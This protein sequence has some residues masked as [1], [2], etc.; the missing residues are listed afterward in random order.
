M[1]RWNQGRTV[2]DELIQRRD[3]ERV[4]AS[5]EHAEAELAQARQHL[6]SAGLVLDLDPVGA[7][8]LAYDAAR[9]ALAAILMNQGL[10]ATSRGGHVAVYETVRAQLDPP[11]GNVLRPFSRM[12]AR[13]NESEYRSAEAPP[14]TPDEVRDDLLKAQAI[15]ELAEKTIPHMSRY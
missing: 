10:R 2:V 15:I 6:A 3:I 9:K 14:V 12:R 4:P 11:L 5:A 1:N 7:Y 13:R 8:S